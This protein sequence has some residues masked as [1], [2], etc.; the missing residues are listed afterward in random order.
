MTTA[1]LAARP[2]CCCDPPPPECDFRVC[3]ETACGFAHPIGPS[4]PSVRVRGSGGYDVTRTAPDGG[5]FTPG[6]P[7]QPDSPASTWCFTFPDAPA[8]EVTIDVEA[9]G[10]LPR[11]LT[12]PF[13][14]DYP[15]RYV[16][17][18]PDAEAT[19]CVRVYGCIPGL[20][21]AANPADAPPVAGA[22]VQWSSG[23]WNASVVT[24][25]DGVACASFPLPPP[26]GPFTVQAFPPGFPDGLL[27]S[28]AVTLFNLASDDPDAARSGV[29]TGTVC[30]GFSGLLKLNV[31]TATHVCACGCGAPLPR[32]LHYSDDYGAAELTYQEVPGLG[33]VWWGSMEIDV[34][35]LIQ[36]PI[37]YSIF[38][39]FALTRG[40]TVCIAFSPCGQ[41]RRYFGVWRET[42]VGGPY[43]TYRMVSEANPCP[44]TTTA[45]QNAYRSAGSAAWDCSRP[46]NLS[47]PYA[48]IWPNTPNAPSVPGDSGTATIT[49]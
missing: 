29:V 16:R 14:C 26:A 11:T 21:T 10:F 2:G 7:G 30:S 46:L 34:E 15:T 37:P 36:V 27:P 47:V 3:V 13:G 23:T 1:N 6:A 20:A 32:T 8:G 22:T 4:N 9:D 45:A 17:L 40:A 24:D 43:A 31:D 44:K 49:E 42:C 19:Y 5:T 12:H 41:L 48:H 18:W 33:G 25:S 39:C 28:N 35:S 38:K